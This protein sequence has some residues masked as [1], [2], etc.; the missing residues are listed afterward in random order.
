MI[1]TYILFLFSPLKWFGVK[2]PNDKRPSPCS[3]RISKLMKCWQRTFC[4]TNRHHQ[5]TF[6]S[7]FG[8]P[9]NDTISLGS[10]PKPSQ[11]CSS[12]RNLGSSSFIL[13]LMKM[14]PFVIRLYVVNPIKTEIFDLNFKFYIKNQ[15][16]K[17]C[18]WFIRYADVKIITKI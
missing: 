7:S 5:P 15:N 1:C 6:G 14:G 3:S 16:R 10:S 11:F 2:W 18:S 9:I 12:P 13:G 4:V 8:Y 17:L